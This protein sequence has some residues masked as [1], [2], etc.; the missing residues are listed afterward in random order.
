MKPSRH[1]LLY[2]LL[3]TIVVT[4]CTLED[5][6][7]W[8][9]AE[10]AVTT[11]FN[12]EGRRTDE[13]RLRTALDYE[14]DWDEAT[15]QVVSATLK[16]QASGTSLAFDP[17]AP[18]AGYSLCHNGHCH[19]DDG[20]LVDYED[21]ALEV[22]GQSGTAG[23]VTQVLEATVPLSSEP[24]YLEP[25]LCSDQCQLPPGDLSSTSVN[26]AQMVLR[27][28]I[29]DL[30]TEDRAR[31]PEEGIEVQLNVP[32]QQEVAAPVSGTVGRDQ[33][34]HVGVNLDLVVS[35]KVWDQVD[36]SLMQD[37]TQVPALLDQ[38]TEGIDAHT[39]IEPRIDR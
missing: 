27:G 38:I 24:T 39:S 28:R 23:S 8:G 33:P 16:L 4:G 2:L 17:A 19:A 32:L 13:G 9:Q 26:L 29:F 25:G 1:N 12:E 3:L 14:L 10:F 6:Q 20:R 35:V 7:P 5:G 21:I 11:S 34:V 31:L 37:P 18:P 36:W 15:L 22:A 30:R